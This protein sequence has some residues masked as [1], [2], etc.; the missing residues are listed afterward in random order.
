V[1]KE[2]KKK[3]ASA[4]GKQWIRTRWWAEP[5]QRTANSHNLSLSFS[6]TVGSTCIFSTAFDVF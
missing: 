3:K 4:L 1:A 2:R 6:D 5:S